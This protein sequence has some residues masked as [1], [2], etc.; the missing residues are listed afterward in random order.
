MFLILFA[1]GDS[2]P[3]LRFNFANRALKIDVL[4]LGK[5]SNFLN[6]HQ[7]DNKHVPLTWFDFERELLVRL[8]CF[9]EFTELGFWSIEEVASLYVL[10]E[11][12]FV[13]TTWIQWYLKIFDHWSTF[14][15]AYHPAQNGKNCCAIPLLNL[16]TP[17]WDIQRLGKLF[18]VNAFSCLNKELFKRLSFV[19]TSL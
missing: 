13:L 4:A 14:A 19:S 17:I 1:V 3:N 8:N 18:Y 5:N 12:M 15:N 2:K 10:R 9:L 7:G 6:G 16:K 11:Q